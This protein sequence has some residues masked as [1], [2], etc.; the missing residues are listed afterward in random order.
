[1]YREETKPRRNRNQLQ[2]LDQGLFVEKRVHHNSSDLSLIG[3]L[4]KEQYLDDCLFQVKD[5]LLSCGSL[6]LARH[7]VGR[8]QSPY[9]LAHVH[10]QSSIEEPLL[11]SLQEERSLFHKDM[12]TTDLNRSINPAGKQEFTRQITQF[13]HVIHNIQVMTN[14]TLAS[15]TLTQHVTIYRQTTC[16]QLQVNNAVSLISQ[17]SHL[18]ETS[19]HQSIN[20][21]HV[22]INMIN[23]Y[24]QIIYV[25]CTVM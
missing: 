16:A 1:M 2:N 8:N 11:S 15:T 23:F 4:P 10:M 13:S 17:H 14:R 20:F 22:I 19:F 3:A 24:K 7:C 21:I 25:L 12:E 9:T 18:I 6:I 5:F